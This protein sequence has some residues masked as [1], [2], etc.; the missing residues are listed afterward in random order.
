MMSLISSKSLS[1]F[2]NDFLRGMRTA[3]PLTLAFIPFGLL[4]GSQATQ[5]NLTSLEIPLLTGLNFAGGSEFAAINLWSLPP[6]I[7]LLAGVTFLINSRH[8][9]MSTSITPYLT[10]FPRWKSLFLLFFLCDEV[11]A[12]SL[13]ECKKNQSSHL[14]LGFYSGITFCLY[15]CWVGFT[16]IG[17]FAGNI[18]H[19]LMRFG[20]DMAFPAVFLILLHSMWKGRQTALP[21]AVS[22]LVAALT[23]HFI[24]GA[25][26]VP[27]G[28]LSGAIVAWLMVRI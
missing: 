1:P 12:L 25:W 2:K 10:A 11:W 5:K 3:L 17:G 8:I 7:I 6:N 9:L 28:T 14:S 23:C 21:W 24:P 19:D 15:V 26:Y 13:T 4:L 22:L 16:F 27:V 20:V 18:I